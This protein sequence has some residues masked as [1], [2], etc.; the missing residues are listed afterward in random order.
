MIDFNFKFAM[1]EYIRNF[2]G[3]TECSMH[4]TKMSSMLENELT[5]PNS[6]VLW[7]WR[8]H[9][10]VNARLKGSRSEDPRLPKRQFPLYNE[11]NECYRKQPPD[12]LNLW[13]NSTK[14][15][16]YY[17]ET[18]ILQFLVNFYSSERIILD[19]SEFNDQ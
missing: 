2:F 4:F 17:D 18:K 19:D 15:I 6:S 7:L 1:R 10:R 14:Y 12:D 5:Y 3:C 13:K 11:C 9:N 8:A 16:E